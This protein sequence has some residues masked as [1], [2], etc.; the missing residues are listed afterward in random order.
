MRHW[1]VRLVYHLEINSGCDFVKFWVGMYPGY[2]CPQNPVIFLL[3]AI[4]HSFLD[5][6]PKSRIVYD[7][8]YHTKFCNNMNTTQKAAPCH[9]TAFSIFRTSPSPLPSLLV[10]YL[11]CLAVHFFL[12][13]SFMKI[14][15]PVFVLKWQHSKLS[16]LKKINTRVSGSSD[17]KKLSC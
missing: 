1:L 6:T 5:Q 14:W 11:C 15:A 4:V 16:I 10:P 2:W 8:P 12:S 9:C 7:E 17:F 13:W 3:S